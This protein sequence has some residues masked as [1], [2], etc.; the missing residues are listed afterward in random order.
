MGLLPGFLRRRKTAKGFG[1]H[2][3]LAFRFITGVLR[4][5]DAGYYDL[6]ELT[7]RLSGKE[8]ERVV[9]LWRAACFVKA[10]R[11]L[12]KGN[13]PAVYVEALTRPVR[14]IA[15]NRTMILASK[16]AEP[17]EVIAAATPPCCIAV[18]DM[19]IWPRL[20]TRLGGL[21]FATADEG[22]ILLRRGLSPMS[23]TLRFS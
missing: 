8:R 20:K 5:N 3:P 21:A 1:V 17:D 2:S 18:T 10:S 4:H 14:A 9:R 15:G 12:V 7:G 13:P 16:G 11:T 19:E 23:Y 6:G 22:Y